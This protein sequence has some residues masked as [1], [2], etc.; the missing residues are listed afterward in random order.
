MTV[1]VQPRFVSHTTI[2]CYTVHFHSHLPRLHTYHQLLEGVQCADVVPL[3]SF[4]STIFNHHTSDV[5]EEPVESP[6]SVLAEWCHSERAPSQPQRQLC[7]VQTGREMRFPHFKAYASNFSQILSKSHY[8]VYSVCL[9]CATNIIYGSLQNSRFKGYTIEAGQN[10]YYFLTMIPP[11]HYSVHH[12][13]FYRT[14]SSTTPLTTTTPLTLTAASLFC[15]LTSSRHFSLIWVKSSNE[16][17]SSFI[18]INW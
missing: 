12:T 10:A 18:F 7:T 15:S 16:H 1:T 2:R 9:I 6:V 14:P 8:D 5:R 4:H 11:L 3:C 13:P 17:L